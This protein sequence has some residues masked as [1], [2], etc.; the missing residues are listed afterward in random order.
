MKNSKTAQATVELARQLL[1]E[2]KE[3]R[4]FYETANIA[5][6]DVSIAAIDYCIKITE[7]NIKEIEERCRAEAEA[8][9][10]VTC[11]AVDV[12]CKDCFKNNTDISRERFTQHTPNGASLILGE[13]QSPAEA[14][15]ILKEQF[16]KACNFLCELEDKLE[17]GRLVDT[18]PYIEEI[19][20]EIPFKYKVIKPTIQRRNVEMCD[21]RES[22][23]RC[24][25]KLTEADK[26]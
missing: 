25:A 6:K 18:T 9:P 24:I 23:E 26:K 20:S 7:R 8:N 17:D 21:S 5:F 19:K 4:R 22:A 16:K 1:K 10:C 12:Q 14:A 11:N 15:A 13:P 2:F 3:Q